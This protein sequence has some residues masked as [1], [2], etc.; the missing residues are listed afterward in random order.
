MKAE[1]RKEIE[2]FAAQV[3]ACADA[4]PAGVLSA[5]IYGE[6]QR[7]T[8]PLQVQ[9][10]EAAFK[11][12]LDGW[13]SAAWNERLVELSVN[14]GG[15]KVFTLIEPFAGSGTTGRA[16]KDLG[17]KAVL[18]EREER[19]CEVAARRMCQE[20]LDFGGTP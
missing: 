1:Q 11:C 15:V 6:Y 20:V 8:M 10:S 17:R 3:K 19:Y 4:M 9:M 14:I 7:E 13:V 12:A 5:P 16:A 18:V 2:E